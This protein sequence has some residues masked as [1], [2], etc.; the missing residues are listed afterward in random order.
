M[1]RSTQPDGAADE[2]STS[3]PTSRTTSIRRIGVA[4]V[5][6][7]LVMPL[8]LPA[9]AGAQAESQQLGFA[10]TAAGSPSATD[11]STAGLPEQEAERQ[12]LHAT[13]P[14]ELEQMRADLQAQAD[15]E[16]AGSATIGTVASIGAGGA[17]IAAAALAQVGDIQDCT[18][19]VEDSL[20]A[21]GI[22]YTAM[23]DL[24]TLGPTIPAA[25]ASPGDLVYYADGGFGAAHVAVAIG[26]GLAVHGGWNGNQ[27][28]ISGVDIP[29]G[30]APVVID[31]G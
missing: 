29:G 3:T 31:I 13:T 28:V 22:G 17:A 19:L 1:T 21:V 2:G 12:A 26:D 20:A 4:G 24:F 5:A 10:A 18:R 8:A 9:F 25:Q 16:A 15:A 6:V 7:A 23:G 11:T 27:T 30:S 14:A